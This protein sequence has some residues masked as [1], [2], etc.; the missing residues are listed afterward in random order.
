MLHPVNRL[1]VARLAVIALA[2]ALTLA[3]V[4][5]PAADEPAQDLV[6]EVFPLRHI[7]VNDANVMLRTIVE[8]RRV[9]MDGE[10]QE[11]VVRD[12]PEKVRMAR[13][14]L[15]QIDVPPPRWECELVAIGPSIKTVLRRLELQPGDL[16]TSFGSQIAG[17]DN[18]TL[19]L[20]AEDMRKHRLGFA[21]QIHAKATAKRGPDLHFSES[22]RAVA[23]GATEMTL[24]TA[25][26][27][28]QQESLAAVVGVQHPVQELRLVLT[29]R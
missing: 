22:T 5:A 23:D 4:P 18:F 19:N 10:R 3:A 17:S 6:Y 1:P 15:A 25:R 9:S 8:M 29:P 16:Q 20:R 13:E 21:Y 14:L 27:A 24:L 11:I 26:L 2:A 7:D 28:Q 12:T